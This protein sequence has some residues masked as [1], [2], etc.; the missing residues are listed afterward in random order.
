MSHFTTAFSLMHEIN[1]GNSCLHFML[2]V[3][4]F[5]LWLRC[6][7]H[8][9]NQ[10]ISMQ[11]VFVWDYNFTII[12]PQMQPIDAG[13]SGLLLFEL[14]PVVDFYTLEISLYLCNGCL[15]KIIT[16]KQHSNQC[17]QVMQ[18][19]L[20]CILC[21][22]WPLKDLH[23]LEAYHTL[24]ATIVISQK[25]DSRTCCLTDSSCLYTTFSPVTRVYER[26]F[27]VC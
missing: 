14:W 18:V 8:P 27:K 16:S 5:G 3:A 19:T 10:L 13:Y 11:P 4:L 24:T 7:V 25:V 9:R 26:S 17:S 1:A 12:S 20:V 21:E 2:V 15:Y 23:F 6:F 22:L